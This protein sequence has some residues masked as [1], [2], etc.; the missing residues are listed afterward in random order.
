MYAY[1]YFMLA[2]LI[3]KL[4][5]EGLHQTHS[6]SV[7]TEASLNRTDD[8]ILTVSDKSNNIMD[9][10]RI[11]LITLL[12]TIDQIS[13]EVNISVSK[14]INSIVDHINLPYAP[15][16]RTI[17][18]IQEISNHIIYKIN[19]QCILQIETSKIIYFNNINLYSHAIQIKFPKIMEEL[20][21]A[22]SCYAVG[23]YTASIFY[24]MTVM[25]HCL[26]RFGH[27]LRPTTTVWSVRWSQ[28]ML[29][30]RKRVELLP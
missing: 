26:R 3:A 30:A 24:L 12:Q 10:E 28:I 11:R 8:S 16:G 5:D 15:R 27:K 23:L 6:T 22:G 1:H 4:H 17:S 19:E 2:Q 7:G 25:E 21:N 14:E 20:K 9:D 29:H 18:C 13:K